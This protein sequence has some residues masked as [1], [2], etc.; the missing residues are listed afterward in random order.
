L[1]AH[2]P[3]KTKRAGSPVANFNWIASRSFS[4]EQGLTSEVQKINLLKLKQYFKFWQH[5]TKS[6]P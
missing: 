5:F 1:S 2:V 6:K 3:L 4:S